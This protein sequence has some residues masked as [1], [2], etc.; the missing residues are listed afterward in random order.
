MRKLVLRGLAVALIVMAAAIPASADE[1]T[2]DKAHTNVD[3]KIKH[4]GISSVRGEFTDYDAT[5]QWDGKDLSTLQVTGTIRATSVDTGNEKRDNHLR[6]HE[7][8][9]V[10]KTPEIKFVSKSVEKVDEDT[11]KMAGEITIKGVTKPITLTV[12]HGGTIPDDG[13][14]NA[15][16]AFAVTGELNRKDFK[17]QMDSDLKDAGIGETVRIEIN[18]E[19]TKPLAK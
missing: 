4:L 5:V 1:W 10:T 18:T 7:F 9:D 13:W 6:D 14:G 11:A 16:A 3:F 8:F 19:V 12:E 2:V 15:R 17:V